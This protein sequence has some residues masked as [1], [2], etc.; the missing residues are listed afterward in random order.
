QRHREA[1]PHSAAHI[2]TKEGQVRPSFPSCRVIT[3]KI[4]K[5]E[6]AEGKRLQAGEPPI[7]GPANAEPIHS[8]LGDLCRYDVR[9]GHEER[10]VERKRTARAGIERARRWHIVDAA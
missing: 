2:D 8:R 3:D 4:V 6:P 10:R 1:L 5:R 7:S 9:M